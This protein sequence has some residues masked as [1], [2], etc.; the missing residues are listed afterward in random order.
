MSKSV[1]TADVH[2]LW[3]NLKLCNY[4]LN[5]CIQQSVTGT[6][7]LTCV[8]RNFCYVSLTVDKPHG[9]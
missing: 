9:S 2:V 7:S 3:K 5:L 4:L 6:G 8:L 1:R